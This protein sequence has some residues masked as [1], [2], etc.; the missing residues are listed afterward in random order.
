MKFRRK[1]LD[2]NGM[3]S[4]LRTAIVFL[5][6]HAIILLVSNSLGFWLAEGTK[7]N[8]RILFRILLIAYFVWGL[9]V[10]SRFAW[11]LVLLFSL[12]YGFAGLF[13]VG[14]QIYMS[15]SS[16]IP[17]NPLVLIV[18]GLQGMVLIG[19]AVALLLWARRSLFHRK[20]GTS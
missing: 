7:M 15:H 17:H 11:C 12:F 13:A 1:Y 8:A 14:Y 9:S 3:A 5:L 6:A 19:C 2:G 20:G 16:G 4:G 10:R 18:L